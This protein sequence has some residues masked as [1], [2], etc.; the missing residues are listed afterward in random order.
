[1]F[2][3]LGDVLKVK[4]ETGSLGFDLVVWGLEKVVLTKKSLN[5]TITCLLNLNESKTFEKL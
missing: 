2:W 3:V 5:K 4:F 1:M